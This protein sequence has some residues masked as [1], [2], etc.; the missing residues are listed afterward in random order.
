[1]LEGVSAGYG[2]GLVIAD[3]SLAVKRGELVALLGPS[4]SGKT[5]VLKLVAGLMTPESGDI[6]FDGKSML[7][8]PAEKR[9]AAMVFQKPLLFPY[10]NVRENVAFGLKMRKAPDLEIRTRV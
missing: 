9:C 10:L 8:I 6:R 7:G 2:R 1:A 4:G 3:F 5:T